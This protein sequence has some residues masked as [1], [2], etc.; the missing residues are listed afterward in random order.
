MLT[1]IKLH[2]RFNPIPPIMKTK[3]IEPERKRQRCEGKKG[4]LKRPCVAGNEKSRKPPL[5]P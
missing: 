3:P 5:V 4:S 2:V 1:S